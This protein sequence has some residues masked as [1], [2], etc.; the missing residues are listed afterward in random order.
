MRNRFRVPRPQRLGLAKAFRAGYAAIDELDSAVAGNNNNAS[1]QRVRDWLARTPAA[2][3][4]CPR[5]AKAARKLSSSSSPRPAGMM[6]NGAQ[7][8]PPLFR[9][10]NMFPRPE[11]K[12]VRKVPSLVNANGIPFVRWKKPQPESISR[13]LRYLIR[14][15]ITRW[16]D[17]DRVNDYHVPLAKREDEWDEMVQK[18]GKDPECDV[19]KEGEEPGFSRTVSHVR[20]QLSAQLSEMSKRRSEWIKKMDY[21]VTEEQRLKDKEDA[22][23]RR[24]QGVE[25]AN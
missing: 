4:Q 24:D 12:G 20:E 2:L 9:F 1:L 18:L 11:V 7:T 13:V 25:I 3:K 23:R 21:I 22:E 10:V 14:M 5:S 17:F 15:R 6:M 8:T 19:L 16:R